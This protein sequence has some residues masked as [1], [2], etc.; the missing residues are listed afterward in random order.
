MIET[1]E[2]PTFSRSDFSSRNKAAGL[3]AIVVLKNETEFSRAALNSIEPYFDEFIIVY[4]ECRDQTP[5]IVAEFARQ[6]GEHVK[7]YHYVPHIAPLGSREHQTTPGNS[8]HSFVYQCNFA[9]SRASFQIRCKWDGDEIADPNSFGSLTRRLRQLRRGSLEWWF[10]PWRLGYWWY[11]G[12]NLWD[13]RGALFVPD[14]RPFMG[15]AKDHGFF[16]AGRWIM[17]K[18]YRGGEY[19]FT[20]LLAKR[21]MGCVCYHLRGLK[22]Q[23]GFEK[24]Q[25]EQNPESL[26]ARRMRRYFANPKFIP[27]CEFRESNA[28]ARQL[29]LP[30]ALGIRPIYER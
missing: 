26:Y 27:L 22:K 14:H 15:H 4:N 18:R 21:Y 23:R 30:E 11:T 9:L 7:V 20:R 3:S 8:V 6:N 2:H 12:L 1:V 5:E 25:F 16:P 17:Y 19:L 24:Y 13:E 28:K 10:S 29:P